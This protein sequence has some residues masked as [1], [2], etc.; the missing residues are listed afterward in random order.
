MSGGIGALLPTLKDR[1]S[2][3]SMQAGAIIATLAASTALA[4][5]IGGRVADRI[6]ARRVAGFGAVLTSALLALVGTAPQLWVV[7]VLIVVGGLGSAGYHPRSAV[8]RARCCQS[9]GNW[10]SASSRV[11]ACWAWQSDR[12][13]SC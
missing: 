2:L 11:A 3:N 8:L 10:R 12:L 4:Q 7:Y 6:G 13:P 1:F 5:P 9:G